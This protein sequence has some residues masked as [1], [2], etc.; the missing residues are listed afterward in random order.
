MTRSA[1]A[2]FL[3]TMFLGCEERSV[4]MRG[5]QT[6]LYVDRTEV[7]VGDEIGVTIEIETP[8]LFT[9]ETPASPPS[10]ERFFTERV[11]RLEPLGIPGGMRHRVVW[12]LRART[13]GEHQLP[14]LSIP[15]VRPD[16]AI[17]RLPVGAVPLPVVSIQ[18]EIPG[19][20][21]YFDI[22][23]P[24]PLE[25]GSV[26]GWLATGGTLL[27]A[28]AGLLLYRRRITARPAP[29]PA[30]A[31]LARE[32]I[33]EI[34]RVLTETDPRALACRGVDVLGGFVERRWALEARG[35]TPEE[36]PPEV[37]ASIAAALR[38]LEAVRFARA[39][40]REPVFEALR[41]ARTYLTHVSRNH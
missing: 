24:P 16:G 34:D 39:P 29:G 3:V 8:E 32:T 35:W 23:P 11:Q 4:P 38:E 1:I 10:D 12:T 40:R 19:R 41:T 22:Q 25:G 28:L 7:R 5:I 9:V 20:T 6:R 30:P 37:D 36:L 18:E 2:F 15:L 17:Q 21:V 26:W 13:V 31:L 33:G 27:V 14:E